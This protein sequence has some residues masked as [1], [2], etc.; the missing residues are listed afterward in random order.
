MVFVCHFDKALVN[1]FWQD[2]DLT[3]NLFIVPRFLSNRQ[4]NNRSNSI[5]SNDFNAS[6][7]DIKKYLIFRW[8]WNFRW[9]CCFFN[10]MSNKYYCCN[11]SSSCT[12]CSSSTCCLW[13]CRHCCCDFSNTTPWETST[14]AAIVVVV[15]VV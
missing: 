13:N 3:Y 2:I 12:C 9:N 7:T 5:L 8:N 1:Q 11:S 15:I 4:F 10:S 6:Y 14:I